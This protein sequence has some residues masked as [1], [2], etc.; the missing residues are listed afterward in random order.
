MT[1]VCSRTPSSGQTAV[2]KRA[3]K[4]IRLLAEM[5]GLIT[6]WN[7]PYAQLRDP[8][9]RSGMLHRC[10]VYQDQ[11]NQLQLILNSVGFSFPVKL[12]TLK[13]NKLLII[14]SK[15]CNTLQKLKLRC[16]EKRKITYNLPQDRWSI[17]LSKSTCSF[18]VIFHHISAVCFT[19]LLLFHTLPENT[20]SKM[21]TWLITKL[22]TA[23]RV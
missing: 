20:S 15:S 22:I 18:S 11:Y 9:H 5:F 1:R 12:E 17:H 13:Q 2:H 7:P 23:N 14:M 8:K 21:I 16:I 19:G 10:R 6:W 4:A 3:G